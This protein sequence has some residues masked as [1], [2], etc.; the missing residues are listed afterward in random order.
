MAIGQFCGEPAVCGRPLLRGDGAQQGE[1]H[2]PA[3]ARLRVPVGAVDNVLPPVPPALYLLRARAVIEVED[4]GRDGE[5]AR[6]PARG[7]RPVLHR[8]EEGAVLLVAPLVRGEELYQVGP[9]EPPPLHDVVALVLEE[10]DGE[11]QL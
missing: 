6:V 9:G 1:D 8:G 5:N 10:G 3:V 7:T 2:S 4:D 11:L